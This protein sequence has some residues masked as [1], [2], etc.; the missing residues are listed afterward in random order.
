MSQDLATVAD[1]N[2]AVA[3]NKMFGFDSKQK[4]QIPSLKIEGSADE[5]GVVK[6]PKGT[7]VYDDGDKLLF[8]E[9]VHIRSFIRAFQYRLYD[10]DNKDKSDQSIIG[11]DFDTEYRSI[12]GRISCGKLG[13]K[14]VKELGKNM[15]KEQ[16]YF[17]DKVKC[18][19]MIFGLVSGNFTNVD[20]KEKVQLEDQLI[21]WVCP[22]SAFI[23]IAETLK[24]IEKERRPVPLTPIRLSLKKEKNGAVTYYMPIPHVETRMATF[25]VDRDKEYLRRITEFIA[26]TND[27]VNTKYNEALKSSTQNDN[28]A[29]VDKAVKVEGALFTDDP[30]D[31]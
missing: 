22:Q 18:K 21:L 9:E 20:T 4:P 23:S 31:L 25:V 10:G 2:N 3:I 13:K 5:E 8:A 26:G 30:L 7:F 12:S 1:G 14:K 19:L 16:Q 24:G 17:Q 11:Q 27:Y 6:A 15:S 29:T 28:F